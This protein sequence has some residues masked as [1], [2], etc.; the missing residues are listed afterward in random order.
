M[1]KQS[2]LIDIKKVLKKDNKK[3]SQEL[4]IE[5]DLINNNL[6]SEESLS[7]SEGY[8]RLM[9]LRLKI[10]KEINVNFIG[11][12]KEHNL[13]DEP[14]A[15]AILNE[16]LATI[17]DLKSNNTFQMKL[18]INKNS[19]KEPSAKPDVKNSSN[20]TYMDVQIDKYWPKVQQIL[21]EYFKES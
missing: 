11:F 17:K 5:L 15:N 21:E 9:E 8:G 1:V 10:K 18:K 2:R 20:K 4:D 14:M 19:N 12:R 7:R 16:R 13:L 6:N 3:A